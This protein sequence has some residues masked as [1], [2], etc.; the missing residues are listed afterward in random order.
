M[1]LWHAA[2]IRLLEESKLFENIQPSGGKIR[3][4]IRDNL[5]LDIHFDPV[6]RSY[7]YALID[8]T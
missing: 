3:A 1:S 6:S 7:S 4:V 2:V 8:L 5:F